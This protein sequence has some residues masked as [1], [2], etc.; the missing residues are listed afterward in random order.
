MVTTGSTS[1][2]FTGN[3]ATVS[4]S[5]NFQAKTA[6]TVVVTVAG[7]VVT[8]LSFDGFGEIDGFTVHL[9][10]APGAGV[11]V[12]IERVT[13]LTQTANTSESS[14]SMPTAVIEAGLDK[15][16]LVAQEHDTRI[17]A[18]QEQV[19][20]LLPQ[21]EESLDEAAASA[22]AAAYAENAAHTAATI[23]TNKASEALSGAT[24]AAGSAT[25]AGTSATAAA[26]SAT[27]AATSATTATTATTTATTKASEAAASATAAAASQSAAAASAATATTQ[28]NSASASAEGAFD[29]AAAAAASQSAAAAAAS[30]TIAAADLVGNVMVLVSQTSNSVTFAIGDNVTVEDGVG[31]FPSAIITFPA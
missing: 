18:G 1:N 23:A 28:A 31:P 4:F 26:G 6:D 8:P 2:T 21:F 30:A 22:A 11:E 27:A 13:P 15:L 3:G 17:T 12:V 25:S 5:T 14:D 24:A 16:T 20:N 9:A 7:V 10:V 19:D 29:A